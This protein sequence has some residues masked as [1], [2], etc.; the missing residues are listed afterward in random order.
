MIFRKIITKPFRDAAII[1]TIEY[2]FENFRFLIPIY[3]M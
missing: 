1:E 3:I 2:I